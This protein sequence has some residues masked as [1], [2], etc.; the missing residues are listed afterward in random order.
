MTVSLKD[1]RLIDQNRWPTPTKLNIENPPQPVPTA[2][3]VTGQQGLLR[4]QWITV[5]NVEGYDIAI[6]TTPNLANPDI[7]VSRVPGQS[8]R[9]FV[10]PCGNVAL[11][12]YFAVR[13]FLGGFVSAWT[14][15]VVGTS[16]VYGA[17]ES[18]PPSPPANPPSGD[19]PLPSGSGIRGGRLQNTF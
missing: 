2:P 17:P 19:E 5:P 11:T 15:P 8:C 7:N 16:V 4:V 12:R 14:S 1:I 18:A 9:E 6:M 13:S 10:Y 3:V